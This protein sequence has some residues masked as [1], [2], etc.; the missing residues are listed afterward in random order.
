VRGAEVVEGDGVATREVEDV[1][2]VAD[3]GA[4]FGLVVWE[5][6]ALWTWTTQSVAC[7]GPT[8]AEDEQLLSLADRYLRE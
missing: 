6:S 8:V 4:V 3:G 1:D 5:T 7:S 2:V